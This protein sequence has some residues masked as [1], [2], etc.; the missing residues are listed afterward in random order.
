MLNAYSL[1]KEIYFYIEGVHVNILALILKEGKSAVHHLENSQGHKC[2]HPPIC[3]K[4][5]ALVYVI[6]P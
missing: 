4:I 2:M 6:N 5:G 1:R 3:F